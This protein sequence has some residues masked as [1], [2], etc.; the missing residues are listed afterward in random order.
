MVCLKVIKG[1]KDSKK[2]IKLLSGYSIIDNFNGRDG[3]RLNWIHVGRKRPPAPYRRLISN[4][5]S[6][7]KRLVPYFEECVKELFTTDEAKALET[8][9][10]ENHG[11]LVKINE[12]S[13]PVSGLF[14]PLPYKEIPPA[15]G[16]G[17]YDL[18]A[19]KGYNLPFKVWAYYDLRNCIPSLALQKDLKE[20]G[21]LY[22]ELA[23]EALNCLSG[24]GRDELG[25]LVESIYDKHGLFAQQGKTREERLKERQGMLPALT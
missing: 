15:S 17:F 8:Y 12:E 10:K 16:R 9:L 22:L 11:I 5:D 23:L 1:G 21:V 6:V 4:Y 20:K 7:D 14:I 2:E 18:S 19:E 3:V 13:L 25:K 24:I